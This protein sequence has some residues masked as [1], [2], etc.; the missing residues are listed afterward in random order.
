MLFENFPLLVPMYD[1]TSVHI[2]QFLLPRMEQ[3]FASHGAAA[4][5]AAAPGNHV[6]VFNGI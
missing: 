3:K 2:I 4:A 5:A 6:H 1:L